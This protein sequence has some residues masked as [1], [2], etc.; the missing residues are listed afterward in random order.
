MCSDRDGWVSK[1][2]P[3]SAE[4]GEASGSEDFAATRKRNRRI[5]FE[6]QLLKHVKNIRIV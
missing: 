2:I 5:L 6:K 1:K 3:I 4:G